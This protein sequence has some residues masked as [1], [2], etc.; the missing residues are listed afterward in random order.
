MVEADQAEPGAAA[1]RDFAQWVRIEPENA[2][3][4]DAALIAASLRH[5][6]AFVGRLLLRR[7]VRERRAARA[8]PTLLA[9][10][11]V[12]T[13]ISLFAIA[14]DGA[15]TPHPADAYDAHVAADGQGWVDVRAT[16]GAS[17]FEVRYTAGMATNWDELDVALRHAVLRLAAHLY[18][19]RDD[20]QAAPP[21]A[22]AALL[23][24]WRR[25]LL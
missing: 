10:S 22:V 17:M 20:D 9:V 12:Q 24:P 18:Q 16:H 1:L 5:C 2:Q 4:L 8:Q 11:P 6:E 21:A 23:R 3:P 25:V 13:P 14:H 19:H 7:A 15:L